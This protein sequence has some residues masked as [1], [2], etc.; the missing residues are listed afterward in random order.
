M[1][2]YWSVI[3]KEEPCFGPPSQEY[4]EQY[5][6]WVVKRFFFDYP[7]TLTNSIDVIKDHVRRSRLRLLD[8]GCGNEIFV[9]GFEKL[10]FEAEGIDFEPHSKK[11]KKVNLEKDKFP[12]PDA[13]FEYVFCR[14]TIEHIANTEHLLPEIYRIL[15]KR[16][17]VFIETP[18]FEKSVKVFY[19]DPT[20][21]KP[22][23]KK[24]LLYALQMAGFKAQTKYFR[25]LPVVWKYPLA[26]FDF[27]IPY[28]QKLIAIGLK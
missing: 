8:V 28:R 17:K 22:W 19:D 18:A 26:A 4:A 16:G 12:Y 11:V 15:K 10:G 27:I 20:H 21:R 6:K 1:D 24:S 2:S 23:T 3:E 25:N 13:S 7:N 14:H 5:C 9:N